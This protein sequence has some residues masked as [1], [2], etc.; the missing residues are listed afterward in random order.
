[1]GC[2][3]SNQKQKA[4]KY[5]KTTYQS[6]TPWGRDTEHKQPHDSKKTIKAVINL[7]FWAYG[8]WD[9]LFP[10]SVSPTSNL[11]LQNSIFND[12]SAIL[13]HPGTCWNKNI[14]SQRQYYAQKM[15]DAQVK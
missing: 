12:K 10:I 2:K 8:S 3:E 14:A 4:S 5:D 13:L 15:Q 1:M 7:Q 6:R 9:A 11:K